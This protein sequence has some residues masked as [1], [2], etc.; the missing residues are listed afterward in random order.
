MRFDPHLSLKVSGD[1]VYNA[2]SDESGTIGLDMTVTVAK[3]KIGAP[4]RVCHPRFR[5]ALGG[6]DLVHEVVEMS[7][8]KG[9]IRKNPPY[10]YIGD[11]SFQGHE[12]VVNRIS[13]D[14]KL[15]RKLITKLGYDP[16]QLGAV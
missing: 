10:Y 8:R 7:V 4:K 3:N 16:V 12:R 11:E 1:P 14:S 5:L 6:F 2:D 15:L 9:V 13:E